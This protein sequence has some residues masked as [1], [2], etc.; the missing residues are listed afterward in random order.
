MIY[1]NTN[2]SNEKKNALLILHQSRSTPGD[3]GLKLFRRGYSLDIR[4]PSLGEKLP[5]SM[6]DHNIA[7]IFGG[8]MSVN[9]TNLDFIKHEIDW[10]NVVLRLD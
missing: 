3:L 5:E 6:N 4:R 8:P 1:K 10:I 2:S 7:I 9:D